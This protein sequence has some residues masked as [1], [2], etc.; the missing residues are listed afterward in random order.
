MR[1]ITVIGNLTVNAEVKEVGSRKAIN[2]AVATNEKY[3]DAQGITIEKSYYYNCTIW[4]DSNVKVA[5][6]LTKGTKVFIEGV[7]EVEIY[8]DKQG[9]IKGSI[10]VIVG[11][12]EL[13]GGGVKKETQTSIPN[14]PSKEDDDDLPF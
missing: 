4:R 12:L 7:P 1:R 3:K 14:S 13:I 8:K 9:E 5:E 6:Y 2:F 11:N 10:K